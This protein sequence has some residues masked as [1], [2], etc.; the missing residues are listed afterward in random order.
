MGNNDF[1]VRRLHSLLGVVPV[2]VFLLEHLITV[3][4]VMGGAKSFDDAV[5][6]LEAIPHELLIFMEVCFIAIP[7]LFHGLYG[8]YIA[9]QAR[10]NAIGGY[11]YTRNW[12][13][14]LQRLT[15][16]YTLLFLIGHVGYLR[17]AMKGSGVPI[18][19]ALVSAHL[20][21]PIIFVLYAIGVVA[22][23]FHFTN[24]LFTFTITWGIAKGPRIQ[25][26]VNK[27]AWA[28]CVILSVLGVVSLTRFIA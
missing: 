6:K 8:A 24:G 9:L 11:G 27:C 25:S 23:V 20:S 13:F 12:Q 5:A 10:N 18:D 17:F 19:F 26:V 14:Y 1:Y 28:L 16:W 7:L 22:A 4:T 3:S 15:A 2:G 21:N